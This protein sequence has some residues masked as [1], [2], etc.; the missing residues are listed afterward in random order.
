[1]ETRQDKLIRLA[2]EMANKGEL[3]ITPDCAEYQLLDYLLTDDELAVMSEM[4]LVMPSTARGLA[5]KTGMPVDKVKHIL[6]GCATGE[7]GRT[8]GTGRVDGGAGQVDA[9]EVN[10]DEGE[11]DRQAGRLAGAQLR[12]RG[13]EDDEHEDEG[14]DELDEQRSADASR[15]GYAVGAEAAGQVRS[16]NDL[17][18]EQQDGAGDDTADQLAAPVAAGVLPAHAA[19]ERDGEGDGRVDV[20]AGD[21]SDRVRHGDDGQTESDGGAHDTGRL[22]APEEH[23]VA[24]AQEHQNEGS[25]AFSKVLFHFECGLFHVVNLTKIPIFR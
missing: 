16:R 10:E 24:A 25:D 12:I 23:S 21:V 20:A 3:K 14:G 6:E 13:A 5:K 22:A 11:T 4:K 18:E 7:E 17:G 2:T 15:V 1:M 9:D 19:G 8:E